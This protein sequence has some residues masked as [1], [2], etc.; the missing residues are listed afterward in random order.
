MDRRDWDARYA[1]H[2]MLWGAEPNRF[3]AEALGALP[4]R[5]RAL[6]VACGEGRNAVWLAQRGF[7]VAALDFSRVALAR[8]AALARARDVRVGFAQADVT[9]LPVAS[10]AFAL[11]VVAYLQVP[12]ADRRRTLAHAARA[13]AP[14]GL[15]FAV[16]HARRNLTEGVGGPGDPA[17]L[18]E[19][20]ELAADLREAGLGVERVEEVRRP[21]GT[22]EGPREAVDLR[23]WARRPGRTP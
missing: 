9:T 17:V 23:A 15:L 8:G 21:V 12:R 3:M 22:D 18:W 14:G 2:E 5:G 11:A 19:P 6:D 10:G 13:L 1:A 20:A 7:R 4:A 16:G